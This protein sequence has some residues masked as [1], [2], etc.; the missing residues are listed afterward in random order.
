MM[1]TLVL[2][3]VGAAAMVSCQQTQQ[4]VVDEKACD[5][6]QL[7]FTGVDPYAGK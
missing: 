7:D 2:T 3:M 6:A 4:Q 1:K 5:I